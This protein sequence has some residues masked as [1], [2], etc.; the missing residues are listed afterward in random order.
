M[1]DTTVDTNLTVNGNLTGKTFSGEKVEIGTSVGQAS[2]SNV[3]RPFFRQ[4][5]GD[6]YTILELITKIATFTFDPYQGTLPLTVN[7]VGSVV[8]SISCTYQDEKAQVYLEI[9]FCNSRHNMV[10][11]FTVATSARAAF[12]AWVR[13]SGIKYNRESSY[14]RFQVG[15]AL[16]KLAS[17]SAAK[18]EVWNLQQ[19]NSECDAVVLQP[20]EDIGIFQMM[21]E[22]G[23]D[24][25]Q[26][27]NIY[28]DL[29]KFAGLGEISDVF[30]GVEDLP[31]GVRYH[32]FFGNTQDPVKLNWDAKAIESNVDSSVYLDANFPSAKCE[33]MRVTDSWTYADW[34]AKSLA[35]APAVDSGLSDNPEKDTATLRDYMDKNGIAYENV[36]ESVRVNLVNL[37]A[38][39]VTK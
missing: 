24:F 21:K 7:N 12:E 39:L 23:V 10:S 22:Q 29:A 28:T 8:P 14:I 27:R 3:F 4:T 17:T 20:G 37:L 36:N 26:S 31:I 13:A 11:T 5:S 30:A 32:L 1:A 2:A 35:L 15:D 18:T 25:L 19:A 33:F 16:A 6:Y 38:S 9:P 34:E